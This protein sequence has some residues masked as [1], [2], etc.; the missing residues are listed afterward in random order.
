MDKLDL[1]V[2]GDAFIDIVVPIDGITHDGAFEKDIKITAGGLANTA[3][4][5]SRLNANVAFVGKIGEDIFGQTYNQDIINETVLPSLSFSD[6][7]TGKCILLVDGRKRTMIIDRGAN[8]D[9]RRKDVPDDLLKSSRYV[10]FSGYSFASKIIQK[11]VKKLMKDVRAFGNTVVFNGGSYN[12]IRDNHSFFE[13]II[14]KY[15]DVFS[16]NEDEAKAFTGERDIQRAFEA[17][18]DIGLPFILT[19]GKEGSVA[20]DGKDVVKNKIKYLKKVVDITGAGDAFMGG[21]LAGL[22]R[23]KTFEEAIPIGHST[24][25][26]VVTR[27]GAR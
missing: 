27:F 21:F 15:V 7:P 3:V 11:E 12:L 13:K 6:K 8:D 25:R 1:T 16:L 14:E 19:L 22:S 20:F 18:K 23:G 2:I 9:L 10:Y 4:W 5:A 24:A 26:K 17:I